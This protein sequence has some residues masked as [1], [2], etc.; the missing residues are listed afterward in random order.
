MNRDKFV[1]LSKKTRKPPGS[2]VKK[3]LKAGAVAAEKNEKEEKI[4]QNLAYKTG[5]PVE[6]VCIICNRYILIRN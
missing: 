3:S 6:K 1:P 4:F 2:R 5:M